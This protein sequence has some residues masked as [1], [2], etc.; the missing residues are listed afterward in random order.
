MIYRRLTLL[1][2]MLPRRWLLVLSELTLA[3]WLR[4]KLQLTWLKLLV[5][6]MGTL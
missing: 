1:W 6:R 5:S 2:L 3:I 4:D